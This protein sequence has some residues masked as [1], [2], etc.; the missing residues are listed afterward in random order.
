MVTTWPE[1][2]GG[3]IRPVKSIRRGRRSTQSFSVTHT[4]PGH[5]R[6]GRLDLFEEQFNVFI[7]F[8]LPVC[9]ERKTTAHNMVDLA[10]C[11]ALIP[12]Q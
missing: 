9:R 12:T 5:I 8:A 7:I 3:L 2:G 4:A 1:A 11:L 10:I 6:L